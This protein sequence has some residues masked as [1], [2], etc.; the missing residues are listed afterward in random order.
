MERQLQPRELKAILFSVLFLALGILVAWL[1]RQY[2]RLEG[3]AIFITILIAP[4]LV[5]LIFSGRLT[6]LRAPGGLE[7]KFV[8]V[9][10]QSVELTS[11]TI[12][13][14]VND[15][16]IVAKGG[17]RELQKQIRRLDES[18][19]IILT[20]TLGKQGY[21]RR[22]ALL[23]YIETLAQY[24]TFKFVVILDKENNFVAY[25]PSVKISQL[26]RLPALGDEFVWMVNEGNVQELQRYPG[27]IT[28]TISTDSTNLNALKEMTQQNLEALVVTGNDQKLKGVVER[29]QII[30]K[31]LL[32]ISR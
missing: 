19:P 8:G 30:S 24:H 25:I 26:L 18:K 10:E 3:D 22:D 6:E 12:E 32:G 16:E 15:M 21:Y 2:L 14:S 5:Y 31:L 28:K 29:E 11:E 7:A 23:Q 9:A 27:I 13:A 4:V 1:A 17:I 20:L